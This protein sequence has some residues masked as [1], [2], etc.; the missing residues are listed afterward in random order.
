MRTKPYFEILAPLV[1]S[2]EEYCLLLRP[3]GSDGEIILRHR[4]QRTATLEQVVARAARKAIGIKVYALVDQD[5]TLAPPGPVYLRAP[6]EQWQ[7][8][9]RVLVRRAQL[10]RDYSAAGAGDPNSFQWEIEQITQ[11][12]V[13][14]RVIIVL[15]PCDRDVDAYRPALQQACVLL[16]TLEGFAG[17]VDDVDQFKIYHWETTLSERTQVLKFCR[18]TIDDVHTVRSWE[19]APRRKRGVVGVKTLQWRPYR[20]ICPG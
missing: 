15:P 10:D 11:R 18:G 8:A 19:A 13:Q 4:G 16:A 6:H 20:S 9:T 5:R 1:R 3:F 17:S 2:N 14:S 12:N 7:S